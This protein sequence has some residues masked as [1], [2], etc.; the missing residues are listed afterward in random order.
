MRRPLVPIACSVF[1]LGVSLAACGKI[2]P[3]ENPDESVAEIIEETL[4]EAG[5]ADERKKEAVK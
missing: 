4:E 1:I 3:T 2:N 5:Q